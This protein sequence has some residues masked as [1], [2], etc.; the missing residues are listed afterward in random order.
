M[1]DIRMRVVCWNECACKLAGSYKK[2][3]LILCIY[4]DQ[5]VA[6]SECHIY[7]LI[8]D[9]DPH[10]CQS[11]KDVNI[12]DS[13]VHIKLTCSKEKIEVAS[14]FV[15][16]STPRVEFLRLLS[17]IFN[18]GAF[19]MLSSV[20]KLGTSNIPFHFPCRLLSLLLIRK[21]YYFCC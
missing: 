19:E 2:C 11:T 1:A 18:A 3:P 20:T 15:L 9:S 7:K 21:Y 10:K 4:T 13:F 12:Y 5:W 17:C 6:L 14:V 8:H 16:E